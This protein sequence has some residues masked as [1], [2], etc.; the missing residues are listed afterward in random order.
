MPRRGSGSGSRTWNVS[1]NEW[2]YSSAGAPAGAFVRWRVSASQVPA[3]RSGRVTRPCASLLTVTTSALRSDVH[4]A[5]LIS[6][7]WSATGLPSCST[8][9][10]ND[11]P[12]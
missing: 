1:G 2:L 4:T 9:K 11:S 5:S 10:T 7:G 12:V 6:T 8:V 3:R